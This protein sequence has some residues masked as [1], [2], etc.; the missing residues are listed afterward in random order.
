[1]T[2]YLTQYRVISHTW[3]FLDELKLEQCASA[4]YLMQLIMHVQ[5]MGPDWSSS[6]A[7]PRHVMCGCWVLSTHCFTINQFFLDHPTSWCTHRLNVLGKWDKQ[8]QSLGAGC[9]IFTNNAVLYKHV[10][11]EVS[12]TG[13][14]FGDKPFWIK[15][16]IC[17]PIYLC[18]ERGVLFLI[19]RCLGSLKS[20]F[21]HR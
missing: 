4:V 13:K 20:V 1:M 3:F 17:M 16:S 12:F 19:Q 2:L 11:R 15:C 18:R 5:S 6:E 9:W 10:N 8:L 7:S 14:C 21:T